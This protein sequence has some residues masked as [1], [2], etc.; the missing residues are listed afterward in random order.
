MALGRSLSHGVA[1]LLLLTGCASMQNTVAQELAWERWKRCNNVRGITLKDIKPDGQIW[2]WQADGGEVTAWRACDR[3]VAAEQAK[4]TKTSIPTSTLAAASPQLANGLSEPPV[5]KPGDEWAYR[6]E[7][8]AGTGTFV[9][10]VDREEALDGVSHY[11]IKSGTRELF[12]RKSDLALSRETV[13]GVV[14]LKNT[15]ARF[16]YV[17]PMQ[18]GQT[19]DQTTLEERPTDR[20]TNE[21]IDT[22]TVESE[23][24]VTVPAGTFNTF[25]LVYKNKR[26]G[27]LRYEAWYSLELKQLVKSRENLASGLRV[28]KLI[29]FKL[30]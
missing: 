2:V 19:W 1:A 20:Q 21:R 11:V 28:R 10:S 17:W 26:T 16:Y 6:S 12:Y 25:K 24:V 5:W 3:A 23:E 22:V 14:V 9:W 15:P 30:R 7:S 4:G 18:V 29:A 8:P 13:D 27:A